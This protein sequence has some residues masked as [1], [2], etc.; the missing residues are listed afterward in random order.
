MSTG[1]DEQ[2]AHRRLDLA[3]C[4]VNERVMATAAPNAVFVRCLPAYRGDEVAARVIDGSR[5]VV[6]A[7]AGNRL[8]VEQPVI[9]TLIRAPISA[10]GD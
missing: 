3:G 1:Q 7:Q 6:F 4:A 10:G 2:R 9:E 8:P 5:P